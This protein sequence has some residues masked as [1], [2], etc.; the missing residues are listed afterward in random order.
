[1]KQIN[2]ENVS[3]EIAA[4]SGTAAEDVYRCLLT[5]YGSRA[6]T[7]GLDRDF[8][9][10]VACLSQPIEAAAALFTAE[11]TRKTAM[12]E[13]RAQVVRVD[14]EEADNGCGEL[15]PKVVVELV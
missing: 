3:V 1:M 11:I 2:I 7:Q 6:G 14:Y 4:S 15:K 8:G 9:L 10:D 12:Y 5:L 13:P